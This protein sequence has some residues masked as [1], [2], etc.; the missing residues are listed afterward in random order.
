MAA[1]RNDVITPAGCLTKAEWEALTANRDR[2]LTDDPIAR[3]S[4][5][6]DDDT[7]QELID[8]LISTKRLKKR[9]DAK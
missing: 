1:Y 4:P 5:R 3:H 6:I 2:P 9:T 7:R 8:R